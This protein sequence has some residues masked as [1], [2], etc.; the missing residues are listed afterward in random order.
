MKISIVITCYNKE[1]FIKQAAQSALD[2]DG[3]FELIV[4]DDFST[5]RSATI[6][7]SIDQINLIK[8]RANLGSTA[9]T[10]IGIERAIHKG[11]D[12]VILLDGDDVLAPGTLRHYEDIIDKTG[13]DAIYSKIRRDP[14]KDMRHNAQRIK[15]GERYTVIS[16]P[17]TYHLN[18]RLAT[19]A[20]CGRPH[21]LIASIT[22]KARVQD[23][24]IGFSVAFNSDHIAISD[25][26]THYSSP[27]VHGKNLS[28]DA[29]EIMKS[30][31]LMYQYHSPLLQ[32][33]PQRSKY[34]RRVYGRSIRLRHHGVLPRSVSTALYI[35]APFKTLL[36]FR[37]KEGIVLW[38]AKY[39]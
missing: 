36:P 31:V 3:L 14:K 39:L 38:V 5:D 20:L 15:A 25:A 24:Q 16:D 26:R 37:V 35:I 34:L 33:H 12:Y 21:V 1:P 29:V 4:V 17:M 22:D 10:R 8:N 23:Y 6:L 18:N 2:Q 30:A 9:T 27:A 11:A 19:T 32:D 28:Q 7:D 13:V